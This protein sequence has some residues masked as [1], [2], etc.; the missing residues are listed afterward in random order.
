MYPG[1][2]FTKYSEVGV[3]GRASIQ[4]AAYG[5]VAALTD[6][7]DTLLKAS[8]M[9]CVAEEEEEEAC[10]NPA[11][12]EALEA[13]RPRSRTLT[14]GIGRISCVT[15]TPQCRVLDAELKTKLRIVPG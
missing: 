8:G 10:A 6:A 5:L 9:T 4:Q 7:R 3:D 1:E 2:G 15:G 11:Q 14:G 12:P 13:V